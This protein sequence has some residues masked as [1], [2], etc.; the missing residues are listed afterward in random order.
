M[1]LLTGLLAVLGPAR[2][3]AADDPLAVVGTWITEQKEPGDPYSHVEIIEHDGVF[4]GRIV[5]LDQPLFP[6]DDP[7][8]GLPRHDRENPE[9]DLRDRP[10]IGLELMH[11]FRFDPDDGKWTDRRIYD[12]ENGKTYRCKLT[13]KDPD[14]LEIFGY[15]KLGFVKL[16]RNTTWKRKPMPAAT[17][18]RTSRAGDRRA[19]SE[20]PPFVPAADTDLPV[21][22]LHPE[23]RFQTLVGIG[24]SFTES[25]AHVLS[26]LNP[27]L[28]DSVIRAY[29]AP[30]GAAYSLTRTHINSC[31]FSLDHYAYVDDGDTALASFTL[32]HDR[33]LLIPLIRDAQAASR[34]GF[35]LVASPWTAPPWMK[36]ND[37]WYAGS[38]KPGM[39]GV[40]A[41]YFA[42]YVEA[43]G[44]EGIEVWGVTPENEPLGNNG[45]WDSM[46]F[47]PESMGAFIRDHLGPELER[48]APGTRI[49]IFDQNRDHVVEWADAILGDPQTARHVWGTA[50]HWYSS[51]I[52][53]CPDA[54]NAVHDRHPDKHL[55]HSEGCVDNQV[56][57]WRDDDWYWRPEATDWGYHW[58][59]EDRKHLHP[60]YVPVYRYARDIIGGLNAWLTGWVDWNMV[61]DTQ[62]GPNLAQNWCCAP[63]IA[64]PETGEVYFTPMFDV[65]AQFSRYLRPGA[66]RIGLEGVPDGVMATAVENPDGTI[67]VHMLNQGTEAVTFV[68]QKEGRQVEM[69]LPAECLQT[70]ALE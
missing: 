1:L 66:V 2:A 15:V 39:E 16:G 25:T 57:V 33:E 52:D 42:R 32:D 31:D 49:L 21:L 24:G 62:G 37:S 12:P 69:T 7:E 10:I 45:Q 56:P 27:A 8:A 65:L 18:I 46:H 19:V 28:R 61:L 6:D 44:D 70:V 23:Q 50:V 59:A 35:R 34:D 36:D 38:L 67:A 53:W 14:T 29:F 4:S 22:E 47:T 51:T 60:P 17:I 43:M 48:S 64:R 55:L 9:A 68:L 58:A 41:R 13:L 20:A 3:L 40:W 63:V 11:G 30:D 5:W 26:R 54:L